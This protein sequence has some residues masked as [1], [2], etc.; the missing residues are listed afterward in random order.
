V[1]ATDR[2]WLAAQ[3]RARFDS[4]VKR[5]RPK[6]KPVA[7][8]TA[9]LR[10]ATP[11][12]APEGDP[13]HETAVAVARAGLARNARDVVLLDVRKLAGYA[14]YFVIMSADSDRQLAAIAEQIEADL[15]ARERYAFGIEGLR[16]GRWA[17]V[18]FGD[19]VAHV[20]HGETRG[21]Y[22]LEGLWSDAPRYEVND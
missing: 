7:K 11:S 20:F 8:P 12:R 10:R 18:D 21:F 6:F 19:V 5:T 3:K 16:G 14:E 15:A 17:L 2:S 9:P 1:T 13:V 22:D 4:V